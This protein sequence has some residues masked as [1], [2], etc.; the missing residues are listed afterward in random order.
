[1]LHPCQC[2]VHSQDFIGALE[3]AE[4]KV[5]RWV[6]RVYNSVFQAGLLCP[7]ALP[8]APVSHDDSPHT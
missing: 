8:T 3:K 4:E 5:R 6:T 7:C 2:N 1:M